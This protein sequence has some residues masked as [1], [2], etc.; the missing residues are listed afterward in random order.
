MPEASV[1][2]NGLPVGKVKQIFISEQSRDVTVS[3]MV[4]RRNFH[5]SKTSEVQLYNPGLIGGKALAIFPDYDNLQMV[6]TGDTLIGIMEI[7][8]MEVVV[9]KVIALGDNV[10]NTLAMLETLFKE[11]MDVM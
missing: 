7:G 8:I 5:F 11:L 4:D 6:E 2:V 9:D 1:T 10:V 3:F